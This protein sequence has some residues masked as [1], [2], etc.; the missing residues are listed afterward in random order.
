MCCNPT[1]VTAGTAPPSREPRKT[2]I[3]ALFLSLINM[4]RTFSFYE[5]CM[6]YDREEKK[7]SS[8]PGKPFRA[9]K[10]P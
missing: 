8:V 3:I 7:T 9:K 1:F 2:A 4:R 10:Y 5:E 6:L